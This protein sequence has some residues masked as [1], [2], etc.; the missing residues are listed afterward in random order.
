[1]S[2]AWE[3]G[4]RDPKRV[5]ALRQSGL[6]GTGPEDP[7]DRF[8]ELATELTGAPRGCINLVDAETFTHKSAVGIGD[9][10]PHSG[11]IAESFC[12]YVVG[13]GQPLIVDDAVN[14]ARTSDNPAIELHKVAA[15]AGY[16]I[17]DVNGAVLG[18]FCLI[19]SSP[20]PWS[21]QDILILATLSQAVST[22]IALRR[23]VTELVESRKVIEEL[24][25]VKN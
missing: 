19:D 9:G 15:W 4:V 25:E 16:P 12:R 23:S 7:F 14:D 8:I 1:M 21:D 2:I 20:H 3:E 11:D 24:R 10:E 18:T 5:L 17:E 22:E 6:V 13:T